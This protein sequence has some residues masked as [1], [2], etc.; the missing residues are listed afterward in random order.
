MFQGYGVALLFAF[1]FNL[2]IFSVL[3]GICFGVF[4]L[5]RLVVRIPRAD[6]LDSIFR[7]LIVKRKIPLRHPL[8]VTQ[9]HVIE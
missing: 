9:R 8:L 5:A 3:L 7:C 6:A 2:L 4:S 1:P